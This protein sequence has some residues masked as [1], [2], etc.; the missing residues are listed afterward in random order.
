MEKGING[1]MESNQIQR[2][3]RSSIQMEGILLSDTNEKRDV[4]TKGM[5]H[6][7]ND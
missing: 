5:A 3:D 4:G 2:R 1:S 6:I 7:S